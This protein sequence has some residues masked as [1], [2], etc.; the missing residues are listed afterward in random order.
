MPRGGVGVYVGY[1]GHHF[2]F[3]IPSLKGK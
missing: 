1:I 2:L 3:R